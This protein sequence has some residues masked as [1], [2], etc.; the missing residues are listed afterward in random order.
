MCPHPGRIFPTIQL[1]ALVAAVSLEK[2]IA[3]EEARRFSVNFA[4]PL[5]C[6]SHLMFP[7]ASLFI[8][9]QF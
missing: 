6:E 5:S 8:H 4:R 2:Y 1:T 7:S 9:C 3:K